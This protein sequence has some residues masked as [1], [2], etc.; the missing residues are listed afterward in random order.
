M[1]RYL[2]TETAEAELQEILTHIVERDGRD[3]SRIFDDP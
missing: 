2:L 1:S 3:L